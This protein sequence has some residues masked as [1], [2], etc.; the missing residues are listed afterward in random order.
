MFGLADSGSLIKDGFITW[1]MDGCFDHLI[2]GMEFGHGLRFA[3]GVGQPKKFI[4]FFIK[5]ILVIGYTM[6][7]K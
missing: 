2:M 7:Q 5:I 1:T 4:R 3:D 6:L